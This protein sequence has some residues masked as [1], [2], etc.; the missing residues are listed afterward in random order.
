[1]DAVTERELIRRAQSDDRAAVATLLAAHDGFC[2]LLARRLVARDSRLLLDDCLQTAR[3]ALLDALATFDLARD[4]RFLTFAGLVVSQRLNGL[5]GTAPLIRPPARDWQ[6]TPVVIRFSE[7][8]VRHD[9]HPFDVPDRPAPDDWPWPVD[10][11]DLRA[12]VEKLRE[13]D[14]SVLR[15]RLAGETMRELAQRMR[16]SKARVQQIEDR[17]AATVARALLRLAGRRLRPP[18]RRKLRNRRASAAHSQPS[19]LYSPP[20]IPCPAS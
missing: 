2:W 4:V 14:R 6:C 18:H 1:M 12:A 8:D 10:R 5:R 16:R 11:R 20:T 13:P 7:L 15:A 19:T 9:G 3:L 17:A